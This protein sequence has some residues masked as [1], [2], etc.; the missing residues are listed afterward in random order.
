M[1]LTDVQ[2]HVTIRN[3]GRP[4]PTSNFVGTSVTAWL[5]AG[6]I[7]TLLSLTIQSELALP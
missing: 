4:N 2:E 3:A 1:E 7:T 5:K 6:G